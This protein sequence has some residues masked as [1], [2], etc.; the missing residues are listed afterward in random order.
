MGQSWG[1]ESTTLANKV[2]LKREI[3]RSVK[4]ADRRP[5]EEKLQPWW[6]GVGWGRL[7]GRERER[8]GGNENV[9][10]SGG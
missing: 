2:E 8:Q 4:W 5:R 7:E 10:V 3:E 9:C 6:Q 1:N